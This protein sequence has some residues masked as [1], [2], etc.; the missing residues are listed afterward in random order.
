MNDVEK[1]KMLK[2]YDRKK[3]GSNNWIVQQKD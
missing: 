1:N 2:R 3:K